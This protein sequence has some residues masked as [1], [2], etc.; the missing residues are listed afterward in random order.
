MNQKKT[1]Y[2]YW[3]RPLWQWGVLYLAIAGILFG[4][5]FNFIYGQGYIPRASLNDQLAK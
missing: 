5:S 4:I 2:R 3:N 1:K